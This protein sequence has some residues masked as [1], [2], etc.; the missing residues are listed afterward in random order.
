MCI[1][2]GILVLTGES[3]T[4]RTVDAHVLLEDLYPGAGYEIKLYAVSHG[5]RSEPHVYFQP[6]CKYCN[7]K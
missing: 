3:V 5:L 2:H 4:R 1:K 6:V 7:H